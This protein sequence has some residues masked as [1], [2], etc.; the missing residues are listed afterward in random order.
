MV[1]ESYYL[2]TKGISTSLSEHAQ[3]INELL[4]GDVNQ[5]DGLK[6]ESRGDIER[7]NFSLPYFS[8]YLLST[9]SLC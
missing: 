6:I 8:C 4:S 7:P 5:T 3:F 2:L 1:K 9:Q